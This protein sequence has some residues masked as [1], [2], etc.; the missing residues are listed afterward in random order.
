MALQRIGKSLDFL[1]GGGGVTAKTIN[2]RFSSET[3]VVGDDGDL[4]DVIYTGGETS[5]TDTSI[6]DSVG[7][8]SAGGN[9]ITVRSRVEFSNEDVAR[10]QTES[11][12]F[13]F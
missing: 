1:S 9:T 5:T 6:G 11:L 10:T 13:A 8:L 4:L 2:K 12:A 3:E 7:T